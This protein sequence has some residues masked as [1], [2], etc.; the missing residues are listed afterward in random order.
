MFPACHL[1]GLQE[2]IDNFDT[3]S[4]IEVTW[5]TSHIEVNVR[6]EKYRAK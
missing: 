5:V 2:V 1:I 4:I 6:L 3:V